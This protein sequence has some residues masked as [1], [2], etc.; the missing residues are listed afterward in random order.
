MLRWTVEQG[1]SNRPVAI[2]ELFA[3]GTENVQL[4][5]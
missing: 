5:D 4:K 1:L 3:R 2:E